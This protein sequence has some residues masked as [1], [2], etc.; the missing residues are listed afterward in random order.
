MIAPLALALA[1]ALA[2]VCGRCAAHPLDAGGGGAAGEGPAMEPALLAKLEGKVPN[3]GSAAVGDIKYSLLNCSVAAFEDIGF[4]AT[5]EKLA[6]DCSIKLA[7]ANALKAWAAVSA[8]PTTIAYPGAAAPLQSEFSALMD[9]AVQAH[10]QRINFT[11]QV[12]AALRRYDDEV[13]AQTVPYFDESGKEGGEALPHG[14]QQE[15]VI[16][17]R[18]RDD[19]E[20]ELARA[21]G[22]KCSGA[23]TQAQDIA[24]GA[25]MAAAEAVAGMRYVNGTFAAV[26]AQFT[27]V[28]TVVDKTTP[29]V[30]LK[31][32]VAKPACDKSTVGADVVQAEKAGD[33]EEVYTCKYSDADKAYVYSVSSGG[34]LKKV[35]ATAGE[36]LP[37]CLYGKSEGAQALVMW[38]PH[39]SA[40]HLCTLVAPGETAWRR[41]TAASY[42]SSVEAEA[43]ISKGMDSSKGIA[44]GTHNVYSDINMPFIQTYIKSGKSKFIGAPTDPPFRLSIR[45]LE[46][47][48][49]GE[50]E[51]ESLVI[52][53]GVIGVYPTYRYLIKVEQGKLTLK[54]CIVEQFNQY[55]IG[56]GAL[57][58][59]GGSAFISNS[60]FRWNRGSYSSAIYGNDYGGII[61]ASVT[62][63]NTKFIGN[64][65]GSVVRATG[66]KSSSSTFLLT[67]CTFQSNDAGSIVHAAEYSAVTLAS[68]TFLN[69]IGKDYTATTGNYGKIS[70]KIITCGDPGAVA[71]AIK[72]GGDYTYGKVVTYTCPAAKPYGG[73]ART[74]QWSG[75]WTAKPPGCV[76]N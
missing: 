55:S 24:E 57:W 13:L 33:D 16:G 22:A 70:T 74:C 28:K 11:E 31:P 56:Y 46:V 14:Q 64:I 59:N 51:L 62:V 67:A 27:A 72:S 66:T 58:V 43:A 25:S 18:D 5:P 3:W 15:P 76:A 26:V 35:N 52:G 2:L 1:L 73:G 32:G 69:N 63:S 68:C 47:H 48:K 4:Y 75:Q 38:W 60:I 10:L 36:K 65:Q 34:G 17:D 71:N 21:A 49:G 41:Q 40:V 12:D 8:G 7:H 37:K 19:H 45:R 44:S 9:R 50:L 23:P 61:G 39:S 20:A 29:R 42:G 53:G 30:F 54:K 6:E